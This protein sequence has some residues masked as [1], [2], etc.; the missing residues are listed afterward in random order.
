VVQSQSVVKRNPGAV[1]G[2]RIQGLRKAFGTNVVLSGLDLDVPAGS[3]TAVLGASGSGKTTLLRLVAGF[4]R[5]D[6]GRIELG[7]T[8]VDGP[9]CFVAPERRRIGYV[10]QDGA[11]FPHLTVGANIG[12]GLPRRSR[13]G[14]RATELCQMVGLAGLE[15][16]YPHE[17]SGGQ[18]Q[19]V[20]LARAL[21]V[22]PPIVL[23]DEPFSSL[24]PA[25]RA[26]VRA[27]VRSILRA[28]GVTAV[29]VTHDQDEALSLADFVAVLRDG[30]IAQFGRPQELYEHPVD[31]LMAGFLGEANLV[32]GVVDG[33]SAT[34]PFGV[35]R[36][37]AGL[38][39]EAVGGPV[40]VL[41]R[42]EQILASNHGGA[43]VRGKVLDCE[44]HGHDTVLTVQP[45]T[46]G[47]A[48]I[49]ARTD[50]FD[51]LAPGTPVTLSVRGEVLAWGS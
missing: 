32:H 31:A 51:P 2:L 45:E 1:S 10:P 30:Q 23:M 49:R 38:E 17:L 9:G 33:R 48:P 29:M 28:A 11:L 25:M 22:G 26:T 19:R 41:I 34:T 16:R 37:R 4:D 20:A 5:V 43:G 18:Q 42:P 36:L 39:V 8:T 47:L 44:Y 6:S 27:D 50:G 14:A 15:P 12:F 46:A 3:L 21:A 40:V 35:V 13:G 24:D 7:E